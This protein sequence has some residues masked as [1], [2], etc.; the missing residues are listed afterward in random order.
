MK[1]LGLKE[2]NN[3]LYMGDFKISDLVKEYGSPL[4]LCDE[5]HLRH[6]CDIYKHA[7]VSKKFKTEVTYASKAFI[8]PYLVKIMKDYGFLIDA[9]GLGDL[10]LIDKSGYGKGIVLQ[11]N[12]KTQEE[13]LTAVKMGADTIVCDN[14]SELRLLSTLDLKS[15]HILIRINPNISAHTHAYIQTATST[16]KFGI[17]YDDKATLEEVAYLIK[18]YHLNFA[19]F[20]AHIGSQI[21]DKN[22]FIK[23]AHEMVK[24]IKM[25]K[26]TYGIKS[27]KLDLGGG[28]G[29][30]YL[31]SDP[32]LNL[33]EALKDLVSAVEQELDTYSDLECLAIEPGRS[34]IGDAILTAYHIGSLKHTTGGVDYAFIEGGMGDNIRPALYEAVYQF[35]LANKFKDKKEYTYSIGGKCCESG[36]IIGHD[37]KLPKVEVGDTLVSYDTGAYCYSMSMNYNGLCKGAT[38]FIDKDQLKVAIKRQEPQ[39]V[40]AQANYDI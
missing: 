12:N 32:K 6:T 4:Y 33:E 1:S 19:G 13:I 38:L 16:S 26:D 29:I 5:S 14:I 36:D 28:F 31:D 30:Q 8:A 10:Y 27:K 25:F 17:S 20:Q 9:I 18:T 2:L 3:E 40:Y 24:F 7:F 34:I 22:S 21:V 11:G 35:D 23:E 15:T 39:E 37:I